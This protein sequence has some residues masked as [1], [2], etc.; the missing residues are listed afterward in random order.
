MRQMKHVA[1][2]S[3]WRVNQDLAEAWPF[4]LT[5]TDHVYIMYAELH[6]DNLRIFSAC[7]FFSTMIDLLVYF[8]FN[9]QD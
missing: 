1:M 6:T 4:T 2:L 9:H 8:C 3:S 5:A 7:L